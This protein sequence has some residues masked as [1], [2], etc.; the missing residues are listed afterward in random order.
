MCSCGFALPS[1]CLANIDYH[2]ILRDHERTVVFFAYRVSKPFF[3]LAVIRTPS[4][5]FTIAK[6]RPASSADA[7][8]RFDGGVGFFQS[9]LQAL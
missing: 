5:G 1:D 8:E 6:A 9:A 7:I 2:Q 4:L 3:I